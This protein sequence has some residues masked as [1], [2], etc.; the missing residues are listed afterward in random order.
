MLCVVICGYGSTSLDGPMVDFGNPANAIVAIL[1][2]LC[3]VFKALQISNHIRSFLLGGFLAFG[4]GSVDFVNALGF[5]V[6]RTGV[7]SLIGHQ[8]DSEGNSEQH[9]DNDQL[10][11]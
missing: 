10:H 1:S 4:V 5:Q 2:H 3:E 9:C 6:V 7:S 8:V 11:L